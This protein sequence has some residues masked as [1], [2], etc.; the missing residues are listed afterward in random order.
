MKWKAVLFYLNLLSV[1]VLKE[2]KG[3]K[4]NRTA[5]PIGKFGEFHLLGRGTVNPTS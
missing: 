2:R 1:A 3:G 5:A 4:Q